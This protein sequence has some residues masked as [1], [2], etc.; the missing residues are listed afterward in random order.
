M[1]MSDTAFC[2]TCLSASVNWSGK[3]VPDCVG[4]Y[5]MDET[6][7]VSA[8]GRGLDIEERTVTG[9]TLYNIYRFYLDG[10]RR[11]TVG[12]TL[13]KII[14]VKLLIMFLVLKLFFFPDV[15]KTNFSTEEQRA[16]HVLSHLTETRQ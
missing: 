6:K 16:D 11:M 10:F 8:G 7:S 4:W 15:L 9:K 3:T 12:K 13:W 14:I 2:N 5:T 1:C